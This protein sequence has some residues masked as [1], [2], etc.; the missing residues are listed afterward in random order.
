MNFAT[1][2]DKV[3][4]EFARIALL[5]A[6]PVM[7]IY[8]R[9][10]ETRLKSDLS[11]VTLADERAEALIMDQLARAFPGVPVMAEEACAREGIPADLGREAILVDPLDGTRE[12]IAGN[13]EFTVN[14]GLVRDGKP[15]AGAV[16]APAFG[17]IWWGGAQAFCA[18]V[19]P[20]APLPAMEDCA[21]VRTRVAAAP[22]SVLESRSHQTPET[23]A[24]MALL[25]PVISR[26]MGSSLKICLIAS[27][28]ADLCLRFGPTM[29][30]DTA[31][32][33]AVLRAAGGITLGPD[34]APLRYGKSEERFRNRGFAAWGD[35]TAARYLPVE[36]GA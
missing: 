3:A 11:P 20:D 31:A 29:E 16:Y 30:W 25:T 7:E 2:A 19:A 34:G 8:A 33:D 18:H 28:E 32:A 36:P 21:P 12:F 22:L 27:G 23:K 1:D 9:G 26:P 14:I 15:V 10:P 13:G 4:R 5:A 17:R 6:I 24:A 35:R